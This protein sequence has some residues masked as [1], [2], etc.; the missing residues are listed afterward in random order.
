M[1]D[2][3][4][5]ILQMVDEGFL[6]MRTVMEAAL[7]YLSEDD[8]ADMARANDIILDDEEYEEVYGRG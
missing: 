4:N 6:D 5:K 1:R 8:V 7:M 3:T 2:A